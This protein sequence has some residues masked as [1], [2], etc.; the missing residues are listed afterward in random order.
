MTALRERAEALLQGHYCEEVAPVIRELLAENE[1]QRIGHERDLL[2]V[3]EERNAA[4]ARAETLE[5]DS[6]NAA[7]V[8]AD[9]MKRAE[10][11]EL[12]ARR[13]RLLRDAQPEDARIYFPLAG[14]MVAAV[15]GAGL[16]IAID[17]AIRAE[18][19]QGGKP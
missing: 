15:E 1:R 13:Y 12:D 17:Y 3:A 19:P 10:A 4:I 16:D 18:Q 6:R 7:V 11:A 9:A 2:L 5:I 8:A 14:G